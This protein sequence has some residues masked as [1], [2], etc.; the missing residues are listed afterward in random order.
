MTTSVSGK[1]VYLSGPM[2]DD[3]DTYHAHDFV[4]A[5]MALLRAG[6][7]D[8]Y[9]PALEWLYFGEQHP[10]DWWMRESVNELTKRGSYPNDGNPKYDMLVS[11]P[12]W[13][14]SP[15][16]SLERHVAECCGIECHDLS[17]VL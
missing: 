14:G 16:A 10:H 11:M 6:A 8:V 4:D 12:G 9:D 13:Q 7:K 17:E 15:G 1:V 3:P 5:H 2:S